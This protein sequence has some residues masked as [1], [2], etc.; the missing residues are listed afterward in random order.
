MS[1]SH[2][3]HVRLTDEAVEA[4]VDVQNRTEFIHCLLVDRRGEWN[5]ALMHLREHGWP[6]GALA[7]AMEATRDL[8]FAL[9]PGIRV[10]HELRD[11]ER[12]G[13]IAAKHGVPGD[14][15]HALCLRVQDDMLLDAAALRLLSR[16]YWS[17]DHAV[18]KKVGTLTNP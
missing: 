11:A 8:H 13:R 2:V 4:L 12:I 1:D 14:A 9:R 7:A 5:E 6:P 10:A 3:L 18:R 15:W 16:A 17:E